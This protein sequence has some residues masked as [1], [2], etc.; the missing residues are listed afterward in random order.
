MSEEC[1]EITLPVRIVQSGMD[2]G[3]LLLAG[4]TFVKLL[5]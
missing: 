4:S 2:E 3:T 1:F 5:H